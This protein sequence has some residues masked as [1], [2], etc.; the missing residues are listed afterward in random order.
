MFLLNSFEVGG[1]ELNAIRTAERFDPARIKLSVAA[2]HMVGPLLPRYERLGIAVHHL[3]IPNL[4]GPGAWAE[5]R[6]FAGI[7]RA[8]RIEVLHTHDVYCNIFGVPAGRLARVPGVLA[9]RRWWKRVP[10][11]GLLVP[12]RMAYALAH[13]VLVNSRA[14]GTM[15][16]REERVPERKI[17]MVP[18]FIEAGAFDQPAAAT[19][20]AWRAQRGIPDG[21]LVLGSV[22]R[23]AAVKDNAT[24]LKAAARVPGVHVVLVG[25]GPE[26]AMLEGLAQA[27]GL[28]DRV[29]FTGEQPNRPNLHHYFD[30]SVLCSLSE[31]F[32]NAMLE[33]MAAA[34]P[35]VATPV[36]GV[37]DALV[38]GENGLLF[39]PGDVGALTAALMRLA[40]A[41]LR[42]RLGRA[43]RDTASREYGELPVMQR[44]ASLYAGLAGREA[45]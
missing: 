39:P 19:R 4:Y 44:L 28:R 23:L 12:N 20:Q 9:S 17:S 45:A 18:N 34:R 30:V 8:G 29:H 10:R 13:R 33:A 3:R 14:V 38:D 1:T 22:G 16:E 5:A 32:P 6:R 37:T 35:M 41:P 31:G 15:L 26:R 27:L 40:E 7:M 2:F 43:A 21:A 36:G 42:D 25:D 11:P 24:F